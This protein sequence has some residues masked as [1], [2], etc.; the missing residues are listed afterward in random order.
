MYDTFVDI[1]SQIIHSIAY[2]A[3]DSL[4]T[5]LYSNLSIRF[6]EQ[7]RIADHALY[8][9]TYQTCFFVK[10]LTF[11]IPFFLK[12][13]LFKLAVWILAIT[14]LLSIGEFVVISLLSKH[15]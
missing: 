5:E 10:S 13:I 3:R 11:E 7:L 8:L 12:F 1:H 9:K 6:S 2:N 15:R 14:M 4:L